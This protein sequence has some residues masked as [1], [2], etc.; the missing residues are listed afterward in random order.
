MPR[1]ASGVVVT[2]LGYLSDGSLVFS[3]T[4]APKCWLRYDVGRDLALILSELQAAAGVNS[5]ECQELAII[6]HYFKSSMLM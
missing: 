6:K 1:A 4:G 5:V 2:D 3:L